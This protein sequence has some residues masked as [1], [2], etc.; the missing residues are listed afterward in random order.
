MNSVIHFPGTPEFRVAVLT[1]V[2]NHAANVPG[3]TSVLTLQKSVLASLGVPEE[4][5]ALEITT[6]VSLLVF[7]NLFTSSNRNE[8]SGTLT[9]GAATEIAPNPALLHFIWD[10]ADDGEDC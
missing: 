7:S 4:Q 3:P 10:D 6:A 2:L 1:A 9:I 8:A 5:A